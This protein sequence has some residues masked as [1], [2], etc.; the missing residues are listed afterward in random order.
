MILTFLPK[1]SQLS[2]LL[3]QVFYVTG[4]NPTASQYRACFQALTVSLYNHFNRRE[5]IR[6]RGLLLCSIHV[7]RVYFG[8]L[9]TSCVKY[10]VSLLIAVN[11]SKK[12]GYYIKS[13]PNLHIWELFS[14]FFPYLQ[15]CFYL[16]TKLFILQKQCVHF[17]ESRSL[18]VSST[19][20]NFST[21]FLFGV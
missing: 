20:F 8:S 3:A 10:S 9:K 15:I 1:K 2:V 12:D 19:S 17:P 14:F 5:G 4:K 18:S 13:N 11:A 7:L 6:V 21:A 16:L